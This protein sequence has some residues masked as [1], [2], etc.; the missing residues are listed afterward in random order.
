LLIDLEEHGPHRDVLADEAQKRTV[1]LEPPQGFVVPRGVVHRA[2]APRRTV[3]LMVQNAGT[4]P[5][6][7]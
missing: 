2:R 1:E 3:I 7:N 4:L 6:G 5:T